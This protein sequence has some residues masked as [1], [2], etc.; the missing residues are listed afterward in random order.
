[1]ILALKKNQQV[2]KNTAKVH[3]WEQ[4][5]WKYQLSLDGTAKDEKWVLMDK[6]FLN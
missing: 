3:E 6:I 1:M 2:D 5:M 4:L